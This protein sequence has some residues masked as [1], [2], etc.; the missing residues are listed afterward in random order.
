MQRPE[1]AF[2]HFL[3]GKSQTQLLTPLESPNRL[4]KEEQHLHPNS[5]RG[6]ERKFSFVSA[7]DELDQNEEEDYEGEEEQIDNPDD[8]LLYDD[9]EGSESS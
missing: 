9:E 7:I 4:K 1:T 6:E 8:F 2:E 5:N 3:I